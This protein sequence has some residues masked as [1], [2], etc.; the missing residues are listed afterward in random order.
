MHRHL[1]LWN[2]VHL[3][4]DGGTLTLEVEGDLTLD[5]TL[6]LP[7]GRVRATGDLSLN[8][9]ATALE[10]IAGGTLWIA[11]GVETRVLQGR[12]VVLVAGE[13]KADAV[14]ATDEIR[15]AEAHLSVQALF[16]PEVSISDGASGRITLLEANTRLGPHAVHGCLQACDFREIFGDVEAFFAA[17]GLRLQ[18]LPG[19]IPLMEAHDGR[20]YRTAPNH[21]GP[22]HIDLDA[23]P[24]LPALYELPEDEPDP[25]FPDLVGAAC[26]AS[27]DPELELTEEPEELPELE[28]LL[29]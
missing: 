7:L 26:D 5:S 22:V 23:L 19:A 10:L 11:E 3:R 27:W 21:S 4:T 15:V 25:L 16:A 24:E 13:V 8:T 20:P 1:A 18:D 28:L 12:S 17:R 2:G 6:G 29:P 9:R 14:C